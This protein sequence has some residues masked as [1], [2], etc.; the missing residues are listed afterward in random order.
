[1]K[2]TTR[3]EVGGLRLAINLKTILRRLPHD[4]NGVLLRWLA[5]IDNRDDALLLET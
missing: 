1:M 5:V 3:P 2:A 4:N